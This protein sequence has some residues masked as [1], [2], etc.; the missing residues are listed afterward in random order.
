MDVFDDDGANL[1]YLRIK[2]IKQEKKTRK[3]KIYYYRCFTDSHQCT[4]ASGKVQH[5][6]D[7][8]HESLTSHYTIL[9]YT[10]T[11]ITFGFMTASCLVWLYI[12]IRRRHCVYEN[13][14]YISMEKA[15][16]PPAGHL[17][18]SNKTT[19]CATRTRSS[20]SPR[21]ICLRLRTQI[22][23]Y[24]YIYTNTHSTHTTHKH[25]SVKCE[26]RGRRY[27]GGGG[28]RYC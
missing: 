8:D 18:A 13:Y 25:S 7:L 14:A 15:N 17:G 27:G 22:H 1:I 23:I 21:V 3:T 6:S 4:F 16:K 5:R 26:P 24:I 10:Q 2:P 9:Y 28:A 12:Y 11:H 19:L 20:E